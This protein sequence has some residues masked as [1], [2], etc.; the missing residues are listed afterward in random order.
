MKNAAAAGETVAAITTRR[1]ATN[2]RRQAVCYTQQQRRPERNQHMAKDR[3]RKIEEALARAEAAQRLALNA[4]TTTQAL[5][6]IL[7]STLAMLHAKNTL[8]QD[9]LRQVFFGAA[10]SID[11]MT[12]SNDLERGAQEHMRMIVVAVAKSHGIEIPP[13]GQTGMPRRH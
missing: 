11:Q 6:A 10:A 3:D 12:P 9:D 1:I 5:G 8:A 2:T 4:S 13:P 7:E